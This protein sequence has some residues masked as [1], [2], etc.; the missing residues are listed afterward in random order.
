MRYIDYMKDHESEN[1]GW[2]KPY[3]DNSGKYCL[4]IEEGEV[5]Y[6]KTPDIETFYGSAELKDK[7][8]LKEF[9]MA[10][11]PDYDLY[12]GWSD[13]HIAIEAMTEIGCWNCPVKNICD[14]M[15]VLVNDN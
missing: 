8:V 13:I 5:V 15:E 2:C 12:H 6:I 3:I 1:L 10:V 4:V 9:V 11:N 14:A 7:N